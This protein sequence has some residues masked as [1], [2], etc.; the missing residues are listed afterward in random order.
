MAWP[1]EGTATLARTRAS[2]TGARTGPGTGNRRRP[3]VK[4]PARVLAS[5]WIWTCR[6]WRF[7]NR[8]NATLLA[9]RVPGR[10]PAGSVFPN[11]VCLLR[12]CRLLFHTYSVSLRHMFFDTGWTLLDRQRSNRSTFSKNT[13][14]TP[15][16]AETRTVFFFESPLH[17]LRSST[18]RRGVDTSLTTKT[19]KTRKRKKTTRRS[20]TWR[21]TCSADS[22]D[23]QQQECRARRACRGPR[24]M[25][26]EEN[27]SSKHT[28]L[29]G[30]AGRLA[31]TSF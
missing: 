22:V 17:G 10:H 2:Q 18:R 15:P 31:C 20:P 26:L 6:V 30:H 9:N 1:E 25:A 11:L 7:H 4:R 16:D 13:E 14:T 24:T 12:A 23:R 8:P 29:Q 27:R 3:P 5:H 28:I 21:G 19:T